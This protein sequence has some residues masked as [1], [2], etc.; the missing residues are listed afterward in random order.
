MFISKK[1][2]EEI[3]AE[4]KSLKQAITS[5]KATNK[6]QSEKIK[7]LEESSKKKYVHEL[8]DSDTTDEEKES[9]I[10]EWLNGAKKE[11]DK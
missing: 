10:D 6:K 8:F 1:E 3:R 9:L 11:E 5:L 7:E 4:L 2:L